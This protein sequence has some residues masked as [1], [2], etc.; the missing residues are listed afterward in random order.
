MSDEPIEPTESTAEQRARD[1]RR[2]SFAT[3]GV[4][5][6]ALFFAFWYAL[7]YYRD[8][9]STATPRP[10]ATCR[11]AAPVPLTPGEVTVNVLNA[12]TRAGL[13]GSTS[14]AVA[15]RGFDVG[16]IGNDS[17]NRPVPAV[18]ELRHG[19]KGAAAAKLVLASMPKGTTMF[20]DS[21]A[22]TSVDLVV[23]TAFQR[24][25]PT[26]SASATSTLPP[27]ATP[28]ASP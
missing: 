16:T 24:L 21:R 15:Q 23:G 7:S 17:T 10:T 22:D 11:P 28:A 25:V 4:V 18:A 26:P 27:C 19:S 2:R 3:L 20:R 13:A 12:T 5:L 9:G 1:R 14:D 6:L 8:D